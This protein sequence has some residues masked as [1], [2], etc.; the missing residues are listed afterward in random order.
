MPEQ[1]SSE[2]G[3]RRGLRYRGL[4]YLDRRYRFEQIAAILLTLPLLPLALLVALAIRLDSP[5]PVLFRQER[6]GRKESTFRI[7]KFRT[8]HVARAMED[9]SLVEGADSRIT[10]VG[11]VLRRTHLDEIP[12]LLNVIR[13]EMSLIGPR[14]DPLLHSSD[15]EERYPPYRERREV[16]PGMTGLGQ[17]R[18]GY[19][20]NLEGAR[21]KLRYDLEYIEN[22]SPRLDLRILIGTIGLLFTGRGAR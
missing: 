21:E 17:I 19:T 2:R 6:P 11:R 16:R 20:H 12:Q 18:V 7:A 4:R 22:A 8:M 3:E 1:N 9:S 14:P 15:Y 10:R 13:G 5:G